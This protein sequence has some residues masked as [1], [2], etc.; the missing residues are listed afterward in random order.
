MFPEGCQ[1][2][3][4]ALRLRF[5]QRDRRQV[6]GGL[7][8]FLGE[9][10]HG[11]GH[12]G[13]RGQG[14]Y[15]CSTIH[16]FLYGRFPLRVAAEEP[17]AGGSLFREGRTAVFRTGT[18]CFTSGQTLATSAFGASRKRGRRRATHGL[19]LEQA[20]GTID[21]QHKRPG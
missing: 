1:H 17:H 3:F 19:V 16:G 14:F 10:G 13:E 9:A 21:T 18:F 5:G 12:E 4:A 11:A 20:L 7:A 2:G 6:R 15:E 8:S